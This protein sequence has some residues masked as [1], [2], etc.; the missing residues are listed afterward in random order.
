MERLIRTGDEELFAEADAVRKKWCGDPVHVR[1]IIE[2]SNVC[3]RN[4]L[5]CGLRRDNASLP[6][7][8]MSVEEILPVVEDAERRGVRTIV[9]QSG[10]DDGEQPDK[11]AEMIAA[12]KGRFDVAITLC[13]GVRNADSYE[14]WR[15]AGADRYLL[16]HESATSILYGIFHPDSELSERLYGLKNLRALRYQIGT[17]SIVGLPAQTP[18]DLVDDILLTREIDVDMA[19]FGPFV[20]HPNTPLANVPR[21]DISLSLNVVAAARLVLGPV[22]IPATTSFDAV[23][24]DGRERALR[25][26]ANVVMAN[27]TPERY[28]RLYDIYPSDRAA[29]SLQ[30]VKEILRRVGRP[31]AKDYG[32]SLK[33]SAKTEACDELQRQNIDLENFLE[34]LQSVN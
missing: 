23:A 14:L 34:M 18:W 21:G 9:L 3:S 28:R 12:I 32:H 31:P 17:G 26:G 5:Y 30:R 20:P 11:L 27:L 10:E 6:R 4:C 1:G 25:C 29:N 24:S 8:T 7:Y 33:R 22:H 19:A 16:K 15:E 13:A 2:F